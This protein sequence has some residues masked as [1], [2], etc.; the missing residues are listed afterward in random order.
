MSNSVTPWTVAHQAPLS[1]GFSR[2][3]YWSGY[4]LLQGIFPVQ[5]SNSGFQHCRQP[6]L[7]FRTQN[8][9]LL[10][11]VLRRKAKAHRERGL[12]PPITVLST[13]ASWRLGSWDFKKNS[14]GS[15][16]LVQRRMQRPSKKMQFYGPSSP[17]CCNKHF[18]NSV[19]NPGTFLSRTSWQSLFLEPSQ[20]L[21]RSLLSLEPAKGM[22]YT[23]A[24]C[25]SGETSPRF[26]LRGS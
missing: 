4:S 19:L 3:E 23:C 26:W 8:L 17:E 11:V 12:P 6:W 2:Q 21:Q 24:S 14:E 16:F 1:M 9:S 25:V 5:G 20:A 7:F 22:V 18:L 10:W 15:Y 13:N